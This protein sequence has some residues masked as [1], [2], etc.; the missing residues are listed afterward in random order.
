[1]SEGTKHRALPFAEM[2]PVQIFIS[3]SVA[4][5]VGSDPNPLMFPPFG[6]ARD[7]WLI[8]DQRKERGDLAAGSAS[9]PASR[10]ASSAQPHCEREHLGDVAMSDEP[11]TDEEHYRGIAEK[12]RELARQT[13][14]SQV[15][16]ELYDLADRLDRM[17]TRRTEEQ[18]P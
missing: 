13:H 16:E 5:P 7:L 1:V 12:I 14:I 17:G 8:S 10:P 6:K 4:K 9:A 18:K 3:D 2:P 15:R 11:Q